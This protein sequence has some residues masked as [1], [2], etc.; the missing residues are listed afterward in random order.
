MTGGYSQSP[1][2]VRTHLECRGERDCD[3]LW[4]SAL[5]ETAQPPCYPHTAPALSDSAGTSYVFFWE[6]SRQSKK[7][8]ILFDFTWSDDWTLT[9]G[10]S[11]VL[12]VL[13]Q[14]VCWP[15]A[16]FQHKVAV[17]ADIWM[18]DSNQHYYEYHIY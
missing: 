14:R 11:L 18:N 3:L 9:L 16:P 15:F 5:S 4:A 7:E 17:G 1:R 13:D 8:N 12:S 6:Y 2:Q 10:S